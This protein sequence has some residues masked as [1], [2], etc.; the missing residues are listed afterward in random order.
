[1]ELKEV[2]VFSI[3]DSG[4]LS[5]WSNVPFFFTETLIAK[6]IKVNR[7]NIE[8]AYPFYH[9][10]FHY[11][12]KIYHRSTTYDFFRSQVYFLLARRL[13]KKAIKQHPNSDVDIFMS[14]SFSS[15]GFTCKPIVQFCDWTYD[16]YF[17]KFM[18]RK[19][20]FFEKKAIER[21]DAQ[22]RKADLVFSLFPN[23]TQYMKDRYGNDRIFYLGNVVN[24]VYEVP[25]DENYPSKG[26][27]NKLL[28]IG[29]K[30][31]IEGA[32]VLIE[33]FR[34]LKHQYPQLTLHVVG[35][36]KNDL[37][38]LPEGIFCYGYLNKEVDSERNLY[39]KLIQEATVFINTSPKWGAFSASI[40][41]MYFYT[42]I[43]ITPY[44]AFVETFGENIKF[45]YYCE[46]NS[47]ASVENKII[48]ILNNPSYSELCIQAHLAVKEFTWDIYVDKL[49][50]KIESTFV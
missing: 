40:E 41:A 50:T 37:E 31:Y 6:G 30:K 43:I 8:P 19:P 15:A 33:A 38:N 22:I 2:T 23:V 17:K 28:F 5:T 42:P 29:S 49:I 24:S 20:D 32:K 18:E 4:Q 9:K 34:N 48:H 7:I 21:E 46:E 35:I 36:T 25:T 3:G 12:A 10:F 1:M 13:I 45:G 14:F 39:Y 47:P 11:I 16:Y 27:A 26:N 44:E